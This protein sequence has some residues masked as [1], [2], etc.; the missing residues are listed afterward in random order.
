MFPKMLHVVKTIF[1][2][3]KNRQMILLTLFFEIILLYMTLN[4]GTKLIERIGVYPEWNAFSFL[5]NDTFFLMLFFYIVIFSFSNAPFQDKV[6]SFVIIRCG[7]RI[8]TIAH[9]IYISILSLVISAFLYM[10][11]ALFLPYRRGSGDWGQFWGTLSQNR[12]DY[13]D[14]NYMSIDYRVLWDFTPK[15]ALKHTMCICFLLCLMIGL[16]LYL[17]SFYGKKIIGIIIIVA[18]VSMSRISIFLRLVRL[19]WMNPFTWICLDVLTPVENGVF[20]TVSYAK[21]M[22]CC[23]N[24]LLIVG[25]II[26]S[27]KKELL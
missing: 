11:S 10:G 17:T 12:Q 4:H 22:L 7:K 18:M 16:I 24:T 14:L 8:F 25:I 20:V 1:L 27:Y 15:E 13:T 9:I 23:I 21:L 2:V 5:W 6:S 26:T 19:Y 3:K